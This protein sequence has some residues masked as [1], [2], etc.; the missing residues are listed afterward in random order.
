MVSKG[1][2]PKKSIADALDRVG[3]GFEVEE[4]HKGHRWGV[5]RCTRCDATV[6]LWSSPKVPEDNADRI[7]KFVTRHNKQHAKEVQ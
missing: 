3:P 7:R 5:L 4:I 6:Q 2:H 1:R